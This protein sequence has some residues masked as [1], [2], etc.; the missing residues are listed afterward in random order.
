MTPKTPVVLP[1]EKGVSVKH[2]L[3]AIST[4]GVANPITIATHLDQTTH[5]KNGLGSRGIPM[6]RGSN[7]HTK[8]WGIRRSLKNKD[9]RGK[10]QNIGFMNESTGNKV[11]PAK[12]SPDLEATDLCSS[13]HG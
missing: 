1:V 6:V 4:E 5:T 10:R 8:K 12:A 11:I 9:T 3:E 2:L 13:S 7:T